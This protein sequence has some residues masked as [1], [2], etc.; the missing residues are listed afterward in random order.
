MIVIDAHQDIAYNALGGLRDYRQ[1]VEHHR[2][3]EGATKDIATIGLPDALLGRVALVFSTLFVAP[4]GKLWDMPGEDLS[5]KNP[6]EAYQKAMRQLD[7]YQRIAD[8]DKRV[9]LVRTAADLDAV[10][11]TWADDKSMGDRQ[12]GLVLL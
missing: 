11:A 4:A 10:L 3:R 12:Q 5:Y 8:D 9:R 2:A 7:Y 1:S 6:A